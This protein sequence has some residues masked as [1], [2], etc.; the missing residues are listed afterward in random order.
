[1]NCIK[2][3]ESP[4]SGRKLYAEVI[5][6]REASMSPILAL[7]ATCGAVLSRV[8]RLFVLDG[9]K[10]RRGLPNIVLS[11]LVRISVVLAVAVVALETPGANPIEEKKMVSESKSGHLRKVLD[12]ERT[13]VWTRIISA[14]HDMLRAPSQTEWSP[15]RLQGVLGNAFSFEMK[16]GGGDVW[17]EG[18][19]DWWLVFETRP[20]EDLGCRI[21]R[22]QTR[23][24][25]TD[26]D[27]SRKIKAAAW[28]AV[29]ASIDRGIPA[30]AWAPMYPKEDSARDW[31]LL[32][33]YDEADESFIVRR[34][35][36]EFGV[37][38]DEIGDVDPPEDFCVFVYDGSEQ[39]DVPSTHV[40]ALRNAV[41]FA[42]GTRYDTDKAPIKVDARGLAAFE[43]WRDAIDSGASPDPGQRHPRSHGIVKDTQSHAGVLTSLR[44]YAAA[45]LRD[46]TDVFPVAG[47]ELRSAAGHYDRVAEASGKLYS[48]CERSVPADE[49]TDDAR[50]EA[51]RLISTALQAER[52]AIAS[53]KAALALIEATE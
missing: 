23:Q 5:V 20:E 52:N 16:K 4:E 8:R 19:L 26:P 17:Q 30:A 36:G 34:R 49:F 25:V 21:Q 18:N 51:S 28:D 45:Y 11:F 6:K 38:Y 32:V 37:R 3:P 24:E 50:A 43:L 22:F 48:V 14:F 15:A 13:K 2:Q 12:I 40:K 47:S 31:G 27:E 29:R 44:R 7:A 10:V 35:G 39:G 42:N 9:G 33:G 53:V 1:M 46:L 41:A